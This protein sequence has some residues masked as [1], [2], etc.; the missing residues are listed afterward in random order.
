MA[1][2]TSIPP[3]LQSIRGF[4]PNVI[5]VSRCATPFQIPSDPI[6]SCQL[7]N[8]VAGAPIRKAGYAGI[9]GKRNPRCLTSN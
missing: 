7:Q 8:R 3:C 1:F 9:G 5:Q 6:P 4:E 2:D